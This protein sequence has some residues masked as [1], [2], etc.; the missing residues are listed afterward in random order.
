MQDEGS[1]RVGNGRSRRVRFSL[2]T[3]LILFALCAL[4]LG[5]ALTASKLWRVQQELDALRDEM[6]YLTISRP[7]RLHAIPVPSIE[8]LNWRWRLHVPRDRKFAL[9]WATTQVPVKGLPTPEVTHYSTGDFSELPEGPFI[10]H[11]GVYPDPQ[12]NCRIEWRLPGNG[13]SFPVREGT[14]DWLFDSTGSFGIGLEGGAPSKNANETRYAKVGEPLVLLRL[15]QDKKLAGGARTVEMTP[16]D[17]IIV[18]IDEAAG[19]K[20]GVW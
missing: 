18:W 2:R 14:T 15:R 5:N 3:L 12:G 4:T 9:C 17:G 1:H 10:F 8:G 7:D 16:T 6:G 19:K 11:F 20:P 13:K